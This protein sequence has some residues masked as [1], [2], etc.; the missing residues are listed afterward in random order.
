MEA[1]LARQIPEMNVERKP[2]TADRQA[3]ALALPEGAALVEFV[4]FDVLDFKAIPG[5][6]ESQWKPPSYLAFILKAGEPDD[7]HLIDLGEAKPIDQM[8]AT[9]S[10]R[11]HRRDRESRQSSRASRTDST[12]E[13]EAR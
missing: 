3:V 8:I 1:D 10:G 7:V 6:G 13:G 5:R 9:F 4:R 12:S 11:D 2:R